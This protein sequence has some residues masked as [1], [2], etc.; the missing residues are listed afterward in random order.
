MSTT[1]QPTAQ[2]HVLWRQRDGSRVSV[3]CPEPI[4]T[5]NKG[6]GGVDRGDQLRGYY[7]YKV[8]SRKFYKYIYYF[9]FDVTI[10][11]S[12]ILYKNFLPSCTLTT[13][14]KFQLQLARELIGDHCSRRRAGAG[15]GAMRP[16]PLRHFPI[17]IEKEDGETVRKRRRCVLCAQHNKRALTLWFCRECEVF[18]C[19]TGE[20]H[21]D[22]FL[23]FHRDYTS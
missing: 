11:N 4:I 3:P 16:L 18:L 22:C 2:G 6:M 20:P 5:Y 23:L 12:F 14:K 15:G 21:T 19:H 1:S 10:T 13:I 8:K 17:K 7:S 9:L